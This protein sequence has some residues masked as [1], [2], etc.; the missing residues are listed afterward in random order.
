M[1]LYMVEVN[2]PQLGYNWVQWLGGLAPTDSIFF[3]RLSVSVF[4]CFFVRLQIK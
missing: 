1:L 2:S 4:V 3:L